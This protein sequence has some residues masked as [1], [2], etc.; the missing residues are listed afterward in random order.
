M[1]CSITYIQNLDTY[2]FRTQNRVQDPV[3]DY[4]KLRVPVNQYFRERT[5]LV[6]SISD[7]AHFSV[8]KA[9]HHTIDSTWKRD[10]MNERRYL[11][12]DNTLKH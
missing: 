5:A 8:G 7:D 9:H 1:S 11:P 12:R 6:Q 10:P 4:H 2:G 3:V